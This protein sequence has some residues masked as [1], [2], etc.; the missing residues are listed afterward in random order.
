MTASS[1][2]SRYLALLLG[3]VLILV[4]GCTAPGDGDTLVGRVQAGGSTLTLRGVEVILPEGVAPAGTQIVLRREAQTGTTAAAVAVSEALTIELGDGL[5]PAR[6]LTLIFTVDADKIPATEGSAE[7]MVVRSTSAGEVRLHRGTYNAASRRYTVEV[8]HLSNFQLFSLDMG[9]VFE[10]V[11]TGVMQGL[12]LEYPKPGCVDQKAKV[13]DTTY[14]LNQ[15]PQTWVCV[16]EEGGKLVLRAHPNSAIPFLVT[17]KGGAPR[18]ST[19]PTDVK[20][21]TSSLVALAQVLGLVGDKEAAVMPGTTAELRF[22]GAP[23]AVTL[24]FEQYP[25][26]LLMS[27]LATTLDTMAT[28]LGVTFALKD[29]LDG[30]QCL[31]DA[32]EIAG[33]G[34]RLNGEAAGGVTRAF[35]DCIGPMMGDAL[36]VKGAIIVAIAGATPGFLI[37]SALGVINELTGLDQAKV[38]LDVTPPAR[39]TVLAV[40]PLDSSGDVRPAFTVDSFSQAGWSVDCTYDDGSPTGVTPGTHSCGGTADSCAAAVSSPGYPNQLLCLN[41]AFDPTLRLVRA[42]NLTATGAPRNPLPLG[43][44]TTD[45]SRWTLRFGG[46]WGGRADGANGAYYCESGPCKKQQLDTQNQVILATENAPIVD[47]TTT[48]WGVYVG[49]IGDPSVDYPAPV[50]LGVT[51]A[52]FLRNSAS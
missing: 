52:W 8:D 34:A 3:L 26:L 7:R 42:E 41:S 10:E 49:D 45:G 33:R 28:A 4:T 43:L 16:S 50:R 13:D 44:E 38:I 24:T 5:Q 32:A 18:V 1:P 29:S 2:S 51:K 30:L 47:T 39:T 6:P 48:R 19:M 9:K 11:R 17:T 15:P 27:I 46:S 36:G 25:V 20:L 37:A 14:G 40:D 21:A 22:T 12:G 23:D 35:F 31:S